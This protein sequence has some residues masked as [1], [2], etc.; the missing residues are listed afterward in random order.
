MKPTIPT[1]LNRGLFADAMLDKYFHLAPN[2]IVSDIGAGF[3]HME[4]KIGSIGGTWQPFD[5]FKKMDRSIVWDL[6]HP[7]PK[8]TSKAGTVVFLEVL[9]H[10][11]NPL[12]GIGHI[13]EHMERG[14]YLI[15]TTPNPQSAHSRLN[16]ALKGVLYAFQPK[17]L[18]EHHVFTPWEHVVQFF[19]E[20][21]GLEIIE[22]A[23]VDVQYKKQK[24]QSI[25]SLLQSFIYNIIERKDPKAAGMSYG[26]VARKK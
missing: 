1:Y 19:L 13:A 7:H 9:E 26:M 5:Y 18:K 24:K 3:G 21:H 23:I 4:L 14:A 25:K 20:H 15:L 10:L 11:A 6:N 22:Y 17:H 12:L 2:K 16:L 8:E